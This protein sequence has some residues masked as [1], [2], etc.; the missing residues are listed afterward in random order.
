MIFFFVIIIYTKK[1]GYNTPF[2]K[3]DIDNNYLIQNLLNFWSSKTMIQDVY[4]K[5][6]K[7]RLVFSLIYC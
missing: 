5:T 2:F 1:Y 4:F 3:H 7:V 6:V